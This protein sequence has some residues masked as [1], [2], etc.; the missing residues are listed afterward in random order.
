LDLIELLKAMNKTIA[1]TTSGRFKMDQWGR[2]KK[3][4]AEGVPVTPTE[5][6]FWSILF[7]FKPD[8]C[9]IRIFEIK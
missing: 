7:T 1:L 5:P 3:I 8:P 4:T 6:G 9:E 2:L